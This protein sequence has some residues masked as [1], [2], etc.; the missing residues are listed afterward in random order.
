VTA[1]GVL[2]CASV[3]IVCH[4]P[5]PVL[6]AAPSVETDTAVFHEKTRFLGEAADA[7]EQGCVDLP[8]SDDDVTLV[9]TWMAG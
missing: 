3:L 4:S 1:G 8:S 9:A 6:T 5:C 7:G 2:C